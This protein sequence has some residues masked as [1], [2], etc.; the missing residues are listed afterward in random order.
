MIGKTHPIQ[1]WETSPLGEPTWV[2]RGHTCKP[3]PL[4]LYH[5]DYKRYPMS[6]ISL[7]LFLHTH[8]HTHTHTPQGA[9]EV[10]EKWSNSFLPLHSVLFRTELR[11]LCVVASAVIAELSLHSGSCLILLK[12]LFVLLTVRLCV[13]RVGM[14]MCAVPQKSIEAVRSPCS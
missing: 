4:H 14:C 2:Q 5:R 7:L 12:I 10:T 13:W 11:L 3:Q 6:V 9:G 8:T 1:E